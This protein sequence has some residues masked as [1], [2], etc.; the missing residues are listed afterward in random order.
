MENK[1]INGNLIVHGKLILENGNKVFAT[2]CMFSSDTTLISMPESELV[3]MEGEHIDG[4][5]HLNRMSYYVDR[6]VFIL[7]GVEMHGPGCSMNPF[8]TLKF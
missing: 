4:D 7:K 6:N 1:R 3:T 8:K 2:G 5:L